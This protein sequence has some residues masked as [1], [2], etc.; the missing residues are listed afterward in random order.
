MKATGQLDAGLADTL[1]ADRFDLLDRSGEVNPLAHVP[2]PHRSAVSDAA[3]LFQNAPPG[4]DAVRGITR[5][6]RK[7]YSKLVYRQLLGGKVQ[8]Q[9]CA[10]GGAGV[11][12]VGKKDSD[13]LREVWNGS[14]LS[15]AALKPSKPPHLASPSALLNV[16]IS[17][18]RPVLLTKRDGRCLFDQLRVP[19]ELRSW[20][21][22]PSITVRELLGT[23][24]VTIRDIK[25]ALSSGE[26][27]I[28][29][30]TV[31][32]VSVVWPMGFAWSSYLAQCTMLGVC[33]RAH[34]QD[35]RVLADDV[36]PPFDL[37]SVFALATD[38]I[39]HFTSHG[40][41]HSE[42][43]GRDIDRGMISAGVQKHGGK[44]I[45]AAESGTCVGID[46]V[47]G[48]YLAPSSSAIRFV[49]DAIAFILKAFHSLLVSPR[50]LASLLGTMQWH[51][52]LGRPT[53]SVFH[54]VRGVLQDG[55]VLL[56]KEVVTELLHFAL[57]APLLEADVC[58]PW[59]SDLIATDASPAFGFGGSAPTVGG[60]KMKS[61][62]RW[63]L[64]P[65]SRV[66]GCH[67]GRAHSRG[68][69]GQSWGSGETALQKKLTFGQFSRCGRL[70]MGTL[71]P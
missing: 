21:G 1:V 18:P 48:R 65:N 59:S 40:S 37:G 20:F 24:M 10:R 57:I 7:E 44:D 53:F 6:H 45:T 47:G 34:L 11:F 70:L 5:K 16:E 27:F 39:M 30:A 54:H 22:R 69:E 35:D 17:P 15:A 41:R 12:A 71:V 56:P 46:L 29:D 43:V 67:G 31:F 2:E 3:L 9:T 61:L 58:R 52:L 68:I 14:R 13:K 42:Q 23:G 26:T 28:V 38:D 19:E 62:G 36:A 33:R 60:D 49:F 25:H 55:G 64:R 51:C 63:S 32:P 66:Y 8:L 50:Q 4:L